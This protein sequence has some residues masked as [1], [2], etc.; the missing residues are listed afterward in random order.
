MS[1]SW[2]ILAGLAHFGLVAVGSQVPRAFRWN[3]ELARLGAANRRLFWVYG[4]FIVLANVGFGALSLAYAA[5][6]AAGKGAAGGM[7]LF[8]GLY[9]TA[10]L[11][12]Q[13]AVFNTADW[14]EQGRHPV[15]KHGFG[16]LFLAMSAV[17]YAAFVNGRLA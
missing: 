8:L 14:P 4:L 7:A 5:E 13:Y 12:T 17:Y 11:A 16:L 6:I 3:T 15:V 1:E 2:V 9:W 10:R